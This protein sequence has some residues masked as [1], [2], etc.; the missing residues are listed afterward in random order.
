M[1]YHRRVP[2][3]SRPAARTSAGHEHLD[4][5]RTFLLAHALLS[6]RLDEELRTEQSMSLAEYD[7]LVQLAVAPGRRLRM[8]TLADRVLLSRSGVTRL[9][10]RLEA[11]G[12][13]DRTQC[14]TDARGAEAVLTETGLGRL[15]RATRT[16]L[17]GIDRYFMGPLSAD[18][19]RAIG[20]SL[21]TIVDALRGDPSGRRDAGSAMTLTGILDDRQGDGPAP[22]DAP[23][24]GS[25]AER[26]EATPA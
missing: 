24:T 1:R 11:A 14:S 2:G 7:A 22:T 13:V 25:P 26:P 9:V 16:H 4:D 8:S 23:R 17:R 5:W 10:D 3:P 21:G 18:E 20:S 12:L 15:R 19:L 6:R